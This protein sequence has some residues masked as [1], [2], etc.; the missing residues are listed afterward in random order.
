LVSLEGRMYDVR[1][2]DGLRGHDMRTK[3]HGDRFRHSSNLVISTI[4]E[5]SMLV[6]LK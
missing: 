5:G 1:R 4:S 2:M 3:F 6:L